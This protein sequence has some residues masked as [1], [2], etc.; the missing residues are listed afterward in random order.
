MERIT[1]TKYVVGFFLVALCL[2]GTSWFITSYFSAEAPQA[3]STRPI[4]LTHSP[5][6]VS[7]V[8][9]DAG[10]AGTNELSWECPNFMMMHRD[11]QLEAAYKAGW[12]RA[13]D[14]YE[15]QNLG[16]S[17]RECTESLMDCRHS[18]AG[19]GHD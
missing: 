8:A 5:T 4:T 1:G 7:P 10:P 9:V 3:I 14:Y 13:S 18:D 2:F 16:D 19:A 12:H 17:L 15:E 11:A 6:P